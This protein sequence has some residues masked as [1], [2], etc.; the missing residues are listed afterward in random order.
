MF[1]HELWLC[2]C[3]L[4]KQSVSHISG[5]VNR[6][7]ALSFLITRLN[8]NFS[9]HNLCASLLFL[10]TLRESYA[11]CAKIYI[12]FLTIWI[13]IGSSNFAVSGMEEACSEHQF[14][15]KFTV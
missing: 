9:F 14:I 3:G 11:N 12:G 2:K 8:Y 1:A 5:K 4:R 7:Q 6:A 13:S 15:Q 10:K